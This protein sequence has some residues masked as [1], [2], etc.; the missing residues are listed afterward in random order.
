MRDMTSSLTPRSEPETAVCSSI[1][2]RSRGLT[3]MVFES[4]PRSVA[5]AAAA[6]I[7]RSSVLLPH[8]L[9]PS[10][11]HRSFGMIRQSNVSMRLLLPAQTSSSR[12]AMAAPPLSSAMRG[13]G[14]RIV[15]AM[16]RLLA[17][18][19]MTDWNLSQT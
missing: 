7:V 11:D 17:T 12:M 18:S 4:S 8:P 3:A 16:Q 6:A 10:S 1:P 5:S 19:S 9:G 13:A 2:K 15:I 14:T